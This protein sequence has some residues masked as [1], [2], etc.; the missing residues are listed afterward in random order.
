M[1]Y[2]KDSMVEV[3]KRGNRHFPGSPL[4]LFFEAEFILDLVTFKVMKHRYDITDCT[5]QQAHAWLTE[6]LEAGDTKILL[7]VD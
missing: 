3:A 2:F 6:Y 4:S 5:P 7:L 1:R